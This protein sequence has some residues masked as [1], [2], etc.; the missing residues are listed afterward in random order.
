M[1]LCVTLR[2]RDLT[3]TFCLGQ[4]FCFFFFPRIFWVWTNSWSVT[5]M[6]FQRLPH[7]QHEEARGLAAGASINQ[8]EVE[9]WSPEARWRRRTCEL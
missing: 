1:N 4:T 6:S 3:I 5:L 8:A 7:K 2:V 9:M